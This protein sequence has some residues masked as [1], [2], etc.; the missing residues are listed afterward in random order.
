M[1]LEVLAQKLRADSIGVETATPM[2]DV[3]EVGVFAPEKTDPL[4][5]LRHRIRTG[6]QPIRIE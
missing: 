4:Y 1:T 2:N 5:L 6:K 3:V